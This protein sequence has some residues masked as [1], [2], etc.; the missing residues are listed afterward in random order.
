MWRRRA[1]AGRSQGVCGLQVAPAE[2]VA[3][4]EEDVGAP[5]IA[6]EP[7]RQPRRRRGADHTRAL[8]AQLDAAIAWQMPDMMLQ[9]TLLR[10]SNDPTSCCRVEAVL[11]RG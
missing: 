8:T 3:L 9:N 1:V 10:R 2:F 6:R 5:H 7:P 4:D 11:E